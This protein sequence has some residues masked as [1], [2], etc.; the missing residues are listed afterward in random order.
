MQYIFFAAVVPVGF[1]DAGV[2]IISDPPEGA[3]CIV[4]GVGRAVGVA[5]AAA[6]AGADAAD[7]GV[8][9][10]AGA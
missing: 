2:G 1:G 6:E 8:V 3:D 7:D 9:D 4:V 10:G 5:D